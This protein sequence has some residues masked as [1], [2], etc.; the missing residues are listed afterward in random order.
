MWSLPSELSQPPRLGLKDKER[1]LEAYKVQRKKRKEANHERAKELSK[2]QKKIEK[3]QRWAATRL[4]AEARRGFARD[5]IRLKRQERAVEALAGSPP[6]SPPAPA[7]P[8]VGARARPRRGGARRPAAGHAA[9]AAAAPAAGRRRRRAARGPPGLVRAVEGARRGAPRRLGS[10]CVG[11]GGAARGRGAAPGAG[12]GP[13]MRAGAAPAAAAGRG[14]AR[15]SAWPPA[16]PRGARR[17]AGRARGATVRGGTAAA[18][19]AALPYDGDV[20]AA[21]RNQDRAAIRQIMKARGTQETRR[22][23]APA[24]LPPPGLAQSSQPTELPEMPET[25]SFLRSSPLGIRLRR[26]VSSMASC[27]S[28]APRRR[29]VH[30]GRYFQAPIGAAKARVA[31]AHVAVVLVLVL[32]GRAPGTLVLAIFH[33]SRLGLGELH[34]VDDAHVAVVLVLVLALLLGRRVLSHGAG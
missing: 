31:D 33:L 8:S 9:R 5:A 14:A 17:G 16:G 21:M 27:R 7:R 1:V 12:R 24:A 18:T 28:S 11:G 22:A 6:P 15:A 32:G 20:Q 30:E 3:K 19:A 34:L 25:I 29:Q 2:A 26:S 13:R 23:S 10:R 4:Q